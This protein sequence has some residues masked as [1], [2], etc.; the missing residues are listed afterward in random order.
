MKVLNYLLFWFGV[1][2][3]IFL[4]AF[5]LVIP[6]WIMDIPNEYSRFNRMKKGQHQQK[7]NDGFPIYENGDK[8]SVIYVQRDPRY[9]VYGNSYY[10]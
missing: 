6:I 7:N 5:I 8:H 2:L 3:I 10:Y 1:V 9:D 4:L